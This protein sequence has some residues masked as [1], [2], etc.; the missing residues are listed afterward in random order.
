[1]YLLRDLR[2]AEK[3]QPVIRAFTYVNLGLMTTGA[4]L[5]DGLVLLWINNIFANKAPT[6][7]VILSRFS[8]SMAILMTNFGLFGLLRRYY[9]HMLMV[10]A[11]FYG[12]VVHV[13][14]LQLVP[15]KGPEINQSE[16]EPQGDSTLRANKKLQIVLPTESL[17]KQW[18]EER[19]DDELFGHDRR[20]K[21][22]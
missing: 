16:E 20:T 21:S 14:T 11:Q 1:M 6:C 2:K 4:T 5:G 12:H 3:L 13:N 9:N 10:E 18:A 15:T 7:N 19:V 22:T 17:V 8:K